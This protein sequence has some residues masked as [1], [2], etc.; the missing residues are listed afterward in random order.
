MVICLGR[1]CVPSDVS[2]QDSAVVASV[3]LC[4]VFP[5]LW[6]ISKYNQT[7]IGLGVVYCLDRNII[8]CDFE[9]R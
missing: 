2:V 7:D 8:D 9:P 5:F 4:G 3:Y 6:M 1:K